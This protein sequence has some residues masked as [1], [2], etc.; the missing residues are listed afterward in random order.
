M[1]GKIMWTY[2]TSVNWNEGKTGVIRSQNKPDV[3]VGT[4]PEFG[5]PKDGYWT[6]EDLVAASVGS[7]IMTSALF[8]IDRAGIELQSYE[9]GTSAVMEKT[10][11]GLAITKVTVEATVSLKD[12]A[13]ENGL[14]KAMDQAEK[15]CPVSALLKCPVELT[16]QVK[17]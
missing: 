3:P 9:S 11:S 5:G 2:K 10:P 13:Q 6:P 4:P 14:R 15:N 1:K 16:V 12:S 8:F 7:C 17:S